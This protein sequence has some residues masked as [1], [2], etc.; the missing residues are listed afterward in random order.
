VKAA[1]F[2]FHASRIINDLGYN[3]LV[4]THTEDHT[5]LWQWGCF[6]AE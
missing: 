2:T 4:I 3:I 5:P 1:R 6:I